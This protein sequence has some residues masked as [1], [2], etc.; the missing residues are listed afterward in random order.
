MR[1]GNSRTKPVVGTR[2]STW[3]GLQVGGTSGRMSLLDAAAISPT[4]P[5][6]RFMANSVA[7]VRGWLAD[8]KLCS[9]LATGHDTRNISNLAF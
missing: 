8:L 4:L 9:K 1:F 7:T 2:V 5:W 3:L 6:A